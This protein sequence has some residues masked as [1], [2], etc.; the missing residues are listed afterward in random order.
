MCARTEDRSSSLRYVATGSRCTQ[1]SDAKQANVNPIRDMRGFSAQ[2]AP[3]FQICGNF[4]QI[5]N[6]GLHHVVK[7]RV[8]PT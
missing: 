7:F 6:R 3:G 4:D 5:W 8:T 1:L 2:S